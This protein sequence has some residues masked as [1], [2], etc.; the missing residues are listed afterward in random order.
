MAT[1]DQLLFVHAATVD[2]CLLAQY[3]EGWVLNLVD[4]DL[5]DWVGKFFGQAVSTAA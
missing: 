5:H 4:K 3:I 2:M 1:S